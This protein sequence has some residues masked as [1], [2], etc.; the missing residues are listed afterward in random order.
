MALNGFF[1]KMKQFLLLI[2]FSTTWDPP[3]PCLGQRFGSKWMGGG[4]GMDLG[5]GRK[6]LLYYSRYSICAGLIPYVLY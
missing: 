1:N 4:K 6:S 2:S 5:T 3:A